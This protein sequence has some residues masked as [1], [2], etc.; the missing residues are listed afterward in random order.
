MLHMTIPIVIK[1][2]NFYSTSDIY[3]RY[4]HI[5][6]IISRFDCDTMVHTIISHIK[7]STKH[8]NK[9]SNIK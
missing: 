5:L 4:T 6:Q 8:K 1:Y 9:C 7:V 2:L 3:H